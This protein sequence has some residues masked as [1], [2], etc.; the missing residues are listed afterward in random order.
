LAQKLG[1]L[2]PFV[3][4]FPQECM[5]DSHR[6]GRPD[7]R[8]AEG[9]ARGPARYHGPRRGRRRRRRARPPGLLLRRGVSRRS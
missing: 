1:Q 7:A 9:R 2:Q 5:A 4:V 8:L 6:L 3:A